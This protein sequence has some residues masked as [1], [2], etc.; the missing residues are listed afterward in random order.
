MFSATMPR[1]IGELASNILVDPLRVSVTPPGT[2]TA[3]GVDQ[4]VYFVGRQE[5]RALLERILRDTA[6]ERALVFTRTKRGANR[7]SELL[8]RAGIAAA[9][10]HGNKSQSARERALGDFRRGRVPVLVATDIAARGIDVEGISH[11]VNYDLPNVAESYVHRVGRT[12]RAGATGSAI[13][14]CDGEERALLRDIEKLLG[15]RIPVAAGEPE[16]ARIESSPST[17]RAP[18]T[19]RS[20]AARRPFRSR[21]RRRH[22]QPRAR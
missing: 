6:V 12:A 13:S 15:R 17:D 2:K 11:V 19:T 9:A 10:I 4:S 5:K 1:D 8:T 18:D 16:P 22:F 20:P 14:F 3:D 7:V 21:S